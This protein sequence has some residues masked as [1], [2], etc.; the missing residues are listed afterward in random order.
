[1]VTK[2]E[3]I[4]A[5]LDGQKPPYVPWSCGFTQEARAKLHA[6]YGEDDLEVTLHNHILK[7][8]SDIGFFTDLGN[9]HFQDVFWR[10][11]G[12]QHR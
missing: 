11:L 4:R 2:R 8:G 6:Y 1:M 7:L 5:V 12:S 10:S 9:N 3:I